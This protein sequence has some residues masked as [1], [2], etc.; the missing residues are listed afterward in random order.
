ML[1]HFHPALG[2]PFLYTVLMMTHAYLPAWKNLCNRLAARLLAQYYEK[3][4]EED[5][6][7]LRK[8]LGVPPLPY[9]VPSQAA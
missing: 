4:F 1:S 8:R 5:L 3:V 6:Q 2:R 7:V 9:G